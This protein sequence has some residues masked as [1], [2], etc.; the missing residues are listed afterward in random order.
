MGTRGPRI[1]FQP[2]SGDTSCGAQKKCVAA[3]VLKT[4]IVWCDQSPLADAEGLEYAATPWLS[5]EYNPSMRQYATLPP[6]V[7]I[8]R[9]ILGD[10]PFAFGV[11][12]TSAGTGIVPFRCG[13]R[14]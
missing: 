2:R 1:P 14:L 12:A 3:T 10:D 11:F 7:F 6:H 5:M 8:Q 9:M 13:Q 4:E